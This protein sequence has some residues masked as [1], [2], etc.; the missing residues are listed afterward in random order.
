MAGTEA[1]RHGGSKIPAIAWREFRTTVL[2]KAFIIGAVVVPLLM[3]GVAMLAPVFMRGATSTVRGRV[4]IV[5]P[6][7]LVAPLMERMLAADR[8]EGP[9]V[10][11]AP[12]DELPGGSAELSLVV[13]PDPARLPQLR[14]E[15]GRDDLLALLVVPPALVEAPVADQPWPAVELVVPQSAPWRVTARLE[16]LVRAAVVDARLSNLGI[17]SAEQRKL[18]QRPFVDSQRQT[19]SGETKRESVLSRMFVPIGFMVLLWICVFTSGHYLLTTTIEE[20]SSRV[21]E[22]LLSA[23][24]PMQLLTGKLLGQALV[25]LVMLVTYTGVALSAL[26]VF[27]MADLVA[28]I[29]YLWLAIFFVMAYFMIGTMMVAVGSAVSEL[30]EA[31]SLMTPIMLVLMIPFWLWFPI[32]HAPN[33]LLA[34]ITSFIPPLTPFVMVLRLSSGSEPV[35]AWQIATSIVV[36]A[37]STLAM[38]WAASRIFR[39]GILMQGKPPS[40]RELLRWVAV[41]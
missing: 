24:S 21:M 39:V 16:Q 6:S 35:A 11:S 12:P 8:G 13:E 15:L 2:T 38:L 3:I 33:G 22:V 36:G 40:P 27:A 17:N 10:E 9:P 5:D 4:A 31:Q 28:P 7:G 25:S 18:M 32:S 29:Q 1:A 41:R 26:S 37:V 30:R 19:Q 23:V 14:E 20:K 34:T